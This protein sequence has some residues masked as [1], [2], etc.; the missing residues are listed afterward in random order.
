MLRIQALHPKIHRHDTT[1]KLRSGDLTYNEASNSP[2]PTLEAIPCSLLHFHELCGTSPPQIYILPQPT[3]TFVI[4]I[5]IAASKFGRST[6]S[7][8]R[9][10]SYRRQIGVVEVVEEVGLLSLQ[11]VI[12]EALIFGQRRSVG[13]QNGSPFLVYTCAVLWSGG[14]W[15]KGRDK[16]IGPGHVC[17]KSV[18]RFVR[19]K[20]DCI[21]SWKWSSVKRRAYFELLFT[22]GLCIKG[23]TRIFEK[24]AWFCSKRFLHR[25][26][27][28]IPVY[29]NL[30][31]DEFA[32]NTMD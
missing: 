12:F 17:A 25:K 30:K 13:S 24:W 27:T 10:R 16:E 11:P 23:I 15:R 8:G 26:I 4:T 29:T 1:N 28:Y 6:F 18:Y 20:G 21:I 3:C 14:K 22:R 19:V 31:M 5:R 7:I 32:Y 2:E 9:M